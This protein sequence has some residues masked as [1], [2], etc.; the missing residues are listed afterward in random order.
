MDSIVIFEENRRLG[1]L[2]INVS[3]FVNGDQ[4]TSP[5]S[6]KPNV[7]ISSDFGSFISR[8]SGFNFY[9]SA[10]RGSKSAKRKNKGL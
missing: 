3:Y 1:G 9:V 5:T 10:N 7:Q 8:L 2:K 6:S 4:I